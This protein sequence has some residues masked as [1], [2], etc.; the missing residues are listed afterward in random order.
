METPREPHFFKPLLPGF[1][2]GVAIPLDFYSKH[3]QGAEINKPWKLRSDASDQIWEVIREG[4]TLTKG[5]MVFHVTPFGPS[6]CEIQYTHPHIVKEEADA[7]DAPTFSYDYCFLAEVTATN[8]KDDKMFLPVEAMR[9]GALNQ[10]CKEVKLVNKE[11]KSWTARFGFSESDGA[12]YI[13]RGWRKFCRDNRCTNGDLFVFNVVGDGTTTP[14]LCVCPER[15]ECTELLIKHF[16]RIDGIL[17]TNINSLSHLEYF[18]ASVNSFVGTPPSA[19]FAIPSVTEIYLSDN[20]FSGTLEIGNV[21]SSSKLDVLHLDNNNLRGPFPRSISKL[22]NLQTLGISNFNIQG[23]VDFSMFSHIKGLRQLYMSHLNTTTT[24]DLNAV[25]SLYLK[26]ISRLVLSGNHVSTTNKSSVANQRL[27]CLQDLDLSDCGITEFPEILR[28]Q[29]LGM[30]YLDISNNKIKGKLPRSLIHSPTLEVFNVE[31]NKINDSF[32]FW[33]S[34]LQNLQILV[35]RGT[36]PSDFFAS[37][38]AMSTLDKNEEQDYDGDD[39]KKNKIMMLHVLNFSSNAFSGHIPSS[40]AD[41]TALES[42]DVSQNKLSGGIPQELGSLSYLS[43]MNFSHYHLAGLVPGGTQFRTQ[44]CSSFENNSGL[45]GPSLDEAC[46]VTN[47][48]TP[49]RHETLEPEEDHEEVLSWVAA[50]V[51][52]VPGIFF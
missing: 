9:C 50:A 31:S 20:L 52:F 37:W 32:P 12:Y 23:P 44:D 21:S 38:T 29:Q 51:G 4:R 34:S 48:S 18:D 30:I 13:S 24:I 17:P 25:L 26:S 8:Q 3:I 1:H 27:E 22:A 14:L 47:M 19:L 40:L 33:L 39:D 35:L 41:L 46:R 7:D 28:S 49:Q 5:D 43:R 42:L 16:S 2:S 36:L 11:G 6:C 10:Q 45:F 15:K